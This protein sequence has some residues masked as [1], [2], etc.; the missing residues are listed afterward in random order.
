MA[1]EKF[2]D[3]SHQHQTPRQH[4]Q[5]EGQVFLYRAGNG[6]SFRLQLD[7]SDQIDYQDRGYGQHNFH[8]HNQIHQNNKAFVKLT[9]TALFD[10][11]HSRALD[12]E[13]GGCAT[14]TCC[15]D[16]GI[17]GKS[18]EDQLEYKAILVI[19][20]IKTLRKCQ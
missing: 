11:S 9:A 8:L 13:T 18:P 3:G 10:F 17:L 1:E 14:T 12:T 6:V 2:S 16:S 4:K 7:H 19:L 15:P 5:A 20:N